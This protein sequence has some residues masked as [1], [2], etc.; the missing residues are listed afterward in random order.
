VAAILFVL[1]TFVVVLPST[2]MEVSARSFISYPPDS[3]F[4]IQNLPYGV[5][6]RNGDAL[7]KAIGVA[8]GDQVLDLAVIAKAGLFDGPS[9]KDHADVFSQVDNSPLHSESVG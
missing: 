3:D 8:I 7:K 1:N 2:H 4:P 6:H 9:L 5:F